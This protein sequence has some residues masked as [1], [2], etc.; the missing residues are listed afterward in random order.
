MALRGGALQVDAVRGAIVL[1]GDRRLLTAAVVGVAQ[2][3]FALGELV[4]DPKVVVR[5]RIPKGGGASCWSSRSPRR[6]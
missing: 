6:C 3:L 1:H 2:A 5:L 4:Q